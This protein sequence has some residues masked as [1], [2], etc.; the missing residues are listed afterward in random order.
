[1][2]SLILSSFQKRFLTFLIF[3]AV[4]KEQG[5]PVSLL[6]K[7]QTYLKKLNVPSKPNNVDNETLLPPVGA[8]NVCQ[9]VSDLGY[10][11]I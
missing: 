7:G 3:C 6:A 4:F 1:M 8:S 5:L 2:C 9:A 10:R 11:D